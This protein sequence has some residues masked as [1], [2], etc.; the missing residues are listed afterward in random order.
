MSGEVPDD[1]L[2]ADRREPVGAPVV[3]GDP[4]ITGEFAREAAEFD[5]DDP[6]SLEAATTAV[7]T[8]VQ[9][10][11]VVDHLGM[12]QGAA[13]CAALVRGTGSYTAAAERAGEPVSVGFL[14]KWARVHDLPIAIRRHIARGEIP[15]TAA[16][17]IARVTGSARYL[18]AWAALDNGLS[19][20][21]VR[22]IASDV[23]Q[24][25]PIEDALDARGVRLGEMTLE[26]PI[27]IYLELRRRASLDNAEPGE[28]VV[29]ALEVWFDQ[30]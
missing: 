19:V 3:R 24:G 2:P 15:P 21:D 12:L 14:R 5:P 7:R 28:L 27:G 22:G 10:E 6:A 26:L 13:A 4:S 1:D 29:E 16:Q 9:D 30:E 11:A 20:R 23:S 25:T 8:F 18:L 17:H